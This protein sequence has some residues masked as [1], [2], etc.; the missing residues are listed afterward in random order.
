[1][2]NV[3]SSIKHL[4]ESD[5]SRIV[6]SIVACVE[7]ARLETE[8]YEHF[9]MENV[10][11]LDVYEIMLSSFPERNAYHDLKHKDARLP[12]GTS[13]RK[14][15]AFDDE[16]FAK[17]NPG[18]IETWSVIRDA[19]CDAQVKNAMFS[20]LRASLESRI[21]DSSSEMW[22]N[23]ENWETIE[24]HPRPALYRDESGY[25]I[26]PHPDSPLKIVTVQFYLPADHSQ[27]LL[28]TSV[29]RRKKWHERL[30]NPFGS[31]FTQVKKFEF[32]PNSGY[33]FA[34]TKDSFHGR[35]EL[36]AADGLRQSILLLYL[37]KAVKLAY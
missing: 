6:E 35:E 10:F 21:R 26:T 27:R 2:S 18:L 8:P 19:I 20:K 17:I 3:T 28:G 5:T 23:G 15:F 4:Q 36:S 7:D 25:K 9:R 29:Y 33:A 22:V 13:T 31:P 16:H 14:R 34:V 11:P 12:D 30:I 24:A 32:T 37:R 1:M